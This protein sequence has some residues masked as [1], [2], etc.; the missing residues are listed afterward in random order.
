LRDSRFFGV[1][2]VNCA[3]VL[4]AV[5]LARRYLARP[6]TDPDARVLV[7]GGDQGSVSD[8][9]RFIRGNTVSGDAAVAVVVHGP[10]A[11]A[12]P[13]FR[14]LGGAT[15]RD[16]RFHR[17]NRMSEEEFALYGQLCA[18]QVAD[19]VALA[20]RSAGLDTDEIDWLLPDLSN[21]MF[22]RNFSAKSG[23]GLDRICLDLIPVRGHNFGTDAMQALEHADT[24][25]RLRPGDRCAMVAVGQ[26]AYFQ[27]M[28][29]EV[30]GEK[31][32]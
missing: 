7:L 12:A 22:W 8:R 19:T 14:Y 32:G 2:Y 6:G 21:R 11:T 18:G 1:S 16:V 27:S 13:R 25:G 20:A 5:E 26:G 28:V 10:A 3:S 30:V 23:I 15:R 17:S 29:L 31:D 9:A 24:S 4:R